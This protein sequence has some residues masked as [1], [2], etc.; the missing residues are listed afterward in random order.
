[1]LLLKIQTIVS[2]NEDLREIQLQYLRNQPSSHNDSLNPSGPLNSEI[3]A[4]MNE[5]I[6]LLMAENTLMTEQKAILT[7]EMDSLQDELQQRS[8]EVDLL[9]NTLSKT[10]QELKNCAQQGVQTEKERDEAA[11]QAVSLSDALGRMDGEMEAIREQLVLWQQKNSDSDSAISDLKKALKETTSEAEETATSCMR[12]AKAAEDRVKQLHNQLLKASQDSD[13]DQEV[14]R[15]LRRE[16]QSTRQDA[17]GMLQVMSGLERQ[18]TEYSTREAEV[19][20]IARASKEKVEEALTERDRAAAREDQARREIQGLLEERKRFQEK[21]QSDIDAA[22]DQAR[23]KAGEQVR[24]CEAE[25]RSMI[26]T[27]VKTQTDADR[28]M[29]DGKSAE[30]AMRRLEYTHDDERK[31]LENNIKELR[32]LLASAL[33]AKDEEASKKVDILEMNKE[34][35]QVVDKLRLD[36][37]AIQGQLNASERSRLSE[38]STLKTTIREQQKEILEKTRI[39]SRKS[40]ELDDLKQESEDKLATVERRMNEESV[41]LQQRLSTAESSLKEAEQSNVA[42]D[43]RMQDQINTLRDKHS[44]LVAK[45]ESNLRS[46]IETGRRFAGKNRELEANSALLSEE[47]SMLVVVIE[48]ARN[49]ISD[50]QEDLISARDTILDLTESLSDSHTAREEATDRATKVLEALEPKKSGKKLVRRGGAAE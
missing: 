44:A 23:T 14:I 50:L 12:R 6:D 43:Q 39:I 20:N 45:L 35:R 17:E 25:M 38:S 48:E 5:R 47:K 2:E 11:K 10:S 8:R 33:L 4:E 34:L 32:D 15:K 3:L 24:H 27:K 41:H 26:E 13:S 9:S 37:D 28:I 22:T 36:L 49:T 31:G 21:R 18:L 42:E 46:E 30:E 40:K 1:V 19:E 29:R 16:Y 7:G